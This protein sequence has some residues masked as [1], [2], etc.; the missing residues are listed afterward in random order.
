[1]NRPT[2]T[3]ASTALWLIASV[4]VHAGIH[5]LGLPAAVFAGWWDAI[6][7]LPGAVLAGYL[8]DLVGRYWRRRGA[9]EAA[10]ARAAGAPWGEEPEVPGPWA[11][12]VDVPGDARLI[13]APKR[14]TT[15]RG[16]ADG[17]GPQTVLEQNVF[18]LCLIHRVG[19]TES[20]SRWVYVPVA[21][22][23]AFRAEDGS[24]SLVYM[25]STRQVL[26][27]DIDHHG[28]RLRA[29]QV[30]GASLPVEYLPGAGE[31]R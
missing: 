26:I 19:I 28:E 20:L 17:L 18:G 11:E 10:F 9:F 27:V 31:A 5:H 25:M 22:E 12:L 29:W 21:R 3:A 13:G 23:E 4:G 7:F 16:T 1:M 24:A 15:E 30:H 8:L 6:L 2:F 14:G